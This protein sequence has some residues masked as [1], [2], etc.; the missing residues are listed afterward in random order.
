MKEMSRGAWQTIENGEHEGCTA[1][2]CKN[3]DSQQN[4]GVC[5]AMDKEVKCFTT[6]PQETFEVL[7]DLVVD[8]GPS[9]FVTLL[10]IFGNEYHMTTAQADGIC[11][12]TPTGST[13]YSLAAGGSLAHPEIPAILITPICPHTLSFR[14]MLLPDS[15]DVRIVVPYNSRSTAW[16][17]FDGRG[18]VELKQGD[19]IKVTASRYPFPSVCR[20]N[21]SVDWFRAISSTLKWNQRQRQKSFVVLEDDPEEDELEDDD[22]FAGTEDKPLP[23]PAPAPAKHAG[24]PAN[25]P[26]PA[27]S[28]AKPA[29][30]F[31]SLAQSDSQREHEQKE[32]GQFSPG[33][34]S[35]P[36]GSTN[37]P[38]APASHKFP[39]SEPGW[40]QR[41][42][43]QFNL[44]RNY[45]IEDNTQPGTPN[46]G[47]CSQQPTAP[48]SNA[49]STG[50]EMRKALPN[51][52]RKSTEA[53]PRLPLSHLTRTH[54]PKGMRM[55]SLRLNP[56]RSQS[57]TRSVPGSGTH[58][59]SGS[60]AAISSSSMSD[61]P[62]GRSSS[63]TTNLGQQQH[64]GTHGNLA[65]LLSMPSDDGSSQ[66]ANPS[67]P[68]GQ[69]RL[70]IPLE[71]SPPAPELA[72]RSES[73]SSPD[74]YSPDRWGSAGPPKPP[75]AVSHRHMAG[76][77]FR[78]APATARPTSPSSRPRRREGSVAAELAASA[79][80]ARQSAAQR[81]AS[82][83]AGNLADHLNPTTSVPSSPGSGFGG[84]PGLRAS[85]TALVVYGDDDSDSELEEEGGRQ[86]VH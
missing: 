50:A 59:P 16:A 70:S 82:L 49:S 7:N 80:A 77:G 46:E 20:D 72:E 43:T 63:P 1:H 4:D 9:P 86:H 40:D 26:A 3:P 60:S 37:A 85:K 42:L 78:H 79:H 67:S 29:S 31:T 74:S 8:R 6:R 55:S 2:T 45:D 19:H 34:N 39:F 62:H 83:V 52:Q 57:N 68:A 30:G 53:L 71:V 65:K 23:A 24:L 11:I 66:K 75:L 44:R 10:E 33:P 36:F 58:T 13:A 73:S 81:R 5:P 48:A 38:G 18:R 64:P 27:S 32:E 54:A 21:Q 14:P 12:A 28:F 15:M 41:K 22:H 56:S 35:I 76:A 84:R 47:I 17:S 25:S 69:N 61:A 51:K